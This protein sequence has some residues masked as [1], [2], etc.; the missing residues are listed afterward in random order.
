VLRT[1][2]PPSA[3]PKA[4]AWSTCAGSA[5]RIVLALQDHDFLVLHLMI[6]GRLRWLDPDAKP[7]ARITLAVFEFATGM[8]AFHRGGNETPGGAAFRSRRHGARDFRCGRA[9]DH[10]H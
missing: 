9:R 6:A 3:K 8:L 5:R 2:V 1:A 4:G 10:G 7:P